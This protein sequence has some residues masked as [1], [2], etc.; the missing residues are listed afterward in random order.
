[1][2]INKSSLVN[3]Q[4]NYKN[5]GSINFG[6]ANNIFTYNYSNSNKEEDN[7]PRLFPENLNNFNFYQNFHNTD[8]P[9]NNNNRVVYSNSNYIN[10]YNS[11]ININLCNQNKISTVSNMFNNEQNNNYLQTQNADDTR[12]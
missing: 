4:I 7:C 6:L 3:Q 11:N 1:M 12:F 2:N 10:K 9:N 8:I 5:N